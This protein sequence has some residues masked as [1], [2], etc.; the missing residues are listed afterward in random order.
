MIKH[1]F[2]DYCQMDLYLTV[3][4]LT[5]VRFQT[6][7]CSLNFIEYILIATIKKTHSKGFRYLKLI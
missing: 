5:T 4:K 3:R 2:S 7:T 6:L 1:S